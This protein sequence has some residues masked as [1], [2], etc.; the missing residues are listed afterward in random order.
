MM[1]DRHV[2]YVVSTVAQ[3]NFGRL[4]D[5]VSTTG[6]CYVVRRH[7]KPKAVVISVEDFEKLLLSE[8]GGEKLARALRESRTEYNLGETAEIT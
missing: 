7:G 4:I 1:I 2:K 3:N 8:R 6:T 5:D